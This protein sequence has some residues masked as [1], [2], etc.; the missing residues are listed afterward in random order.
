MHCFTAISRSII[1][2]LFIEGQYEVSSFLVT[3]NKQSVFPIYNFTAFLQ[4]ASALVTYLIVLLQF[5]MGQPENFEVN[6]PQNIGNQYLSNKQFDGIMH[7][8]LATEAI[9]WSCYRTSTGRMSIHIEAQARILKKNCH[10]TV[11]YVWK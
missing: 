2:I 1:K 11:K 3:L 5:S 7:I 4:Y 9:M 8:Y 10:S 6:V